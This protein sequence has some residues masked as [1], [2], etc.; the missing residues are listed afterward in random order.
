MTI[1]LAILT[2]IGLGYLGW[3]EPWIPPFVWQAN[4][5]GGLI[6]GVGMVVAATCITGVFY[7]LGH[8]MLGMIVA[9]VAWALGDIVMYLGPLASVRE[10]LIAAPVTVNGKSATLLNAFGWPG[11]GLSMLLGMVTAVYPS[12]SFYPTNGAAERR[13]AAGA[14]IRK[15]ALE[16]WF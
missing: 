6:F 4:L 9:L 7:K 13:A 14:K 11:M 5:I 2:G 16:Q 3:I 15:T 8:G 1:L 12:S 10:A